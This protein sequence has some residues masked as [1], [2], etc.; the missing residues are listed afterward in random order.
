MRIALAS[1]TAPAHPRRT[2]RERRACSACAGAWDAN[3]GEK[4]LSGI[5]RKRS[6]R[7]VN[8]HRE[9]R[10]ADSHHAHLEPP[11]CRKA[12]GPSL[13]TRRFAARRDCAAKLIGELF[14]SPSGWMDEIVE[15]SYANLSGYS[16]EQINEL[17][18]SGKY[19]P[20]ATFE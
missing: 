2:M 14:M 17:T 18:V 1:A 6:C 3:I 16:L 13:S 12:G 10:K 9:R 8:K 11:G 19:R 20:A 7:S 4:S 15:P 5:R